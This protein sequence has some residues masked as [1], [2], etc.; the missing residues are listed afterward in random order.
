MLAVEIISV[1]KRSFTDDT[2]P[3]PQQQPTHGT[4]QFG[5]F[6]QAICAILISPHIRNETTLE[7]YPR[8][9]MFGKIDKEK[10]SIY[11][12]NGNG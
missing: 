7:N 11:L 6:C 1:I 5:V 2:F 8:V 9:K 12:H 10:K 3:L 4:E